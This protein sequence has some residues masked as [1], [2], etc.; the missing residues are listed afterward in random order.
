MAYYCEKRDKNDI[1]CV[2]WINWGIRFLMI[3][4]DF[5]KDSFLLRSKK[6]ILKIFFVY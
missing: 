6:E 4:L 3:N 5:L 1:F 2:L